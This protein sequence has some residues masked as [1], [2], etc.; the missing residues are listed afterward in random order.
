M[1]KTLLSYLRKFNIDQDAIFQIEV[2]HNEETNKFE[3]IC[4]KT[5]SKFHSFTESEAAILL[6]AQIIKDHSS[7]AVIE[8]FKG[9]EHMLSIYD[10]GKLVLKQKWVM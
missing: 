6:K 1:N 5:G 7:F 2:L 4:H 10:C 9:V 3:A 8:P